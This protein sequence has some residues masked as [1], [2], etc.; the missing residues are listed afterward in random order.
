M[1]PI[2]PD[3]TNDINEPKLFDEIKLLKNNFKNISIEKTSL[4]EVWLNIFYTKVSS[5]FYNVDLKILK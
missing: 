4:E 1:K 5:T 2:L 3:S